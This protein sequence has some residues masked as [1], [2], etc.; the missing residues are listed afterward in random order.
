MERPWCLPASKSRYHS[1][2]LAGRVLGALAAAAALWAGCAGEA[3]RLPPQGPGEGV[4][5]IG[6]SLTQ[7]NDLAGLV[8]ALADAAGKHLPATAVVGD[9]F[10]LE[11]HWAS[12][13]ALRAIDRGGWSVVVLQQGPSGQPDS[14][15]DLREW[16]LRFDER[17]RKAGARTALFAVWPAAS[18]PS[19]FEQVAQS[20]SAAAEAVG[21]IYLPVTRA[22]LEAWHRDP[23][24]QLYSGDQ[25]HPASQGSYLAAVTIV[26]VLAG[27][28]P[29]GLPAHVHTASGVDVSVPAATAALLQESAAAANAQFARQSW[30]PR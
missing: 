11:D 26:G 12:G 24:L 14:Q 1:G 25:F 23:S 13:E 30:I 10:A 22:W 3:A 7:A 5:F 8:S 9:G 27:I 28:S 16:T 17:I 29:V 19:S 18:G 20:Y 15:V 4:L 21:G 6:N 2:M